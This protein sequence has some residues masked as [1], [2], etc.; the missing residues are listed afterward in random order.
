MSRCRACN[1]LLSGYDL[2]RVD[3]NGNLEEYCIDCRIA[4]DN[5]DLLDFQWKQFEDQI[6]EV[7]LDLQKNNNIPRSE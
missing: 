1:T 5:P 6:R 3:E 2:R 7:D 4:S